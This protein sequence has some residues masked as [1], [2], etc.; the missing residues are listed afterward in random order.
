MND[1]G[2]DFARP[3]KP[4]YNEKNNSFTWRFCQERLERSLV[5]ATSMFGA[6]TITRYG[7]VP[8]RRERRR[9]I[10]PSGVPCGPSHHSLKTRNFSNRNRDGTWA[11]LTATWRRCS[12][13]RPRKRLG[14]RPSVLQSPGG[15]IPALLEPCPTT[16]WP[17]VRRGM[18]YAAAFTMSS[19]TFFASPN[20]IMVLSM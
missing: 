10:L 8:H 3:G 14:A 16:R 15:K 17:F 2:I 11:S 9:M 13:I 19:I 20:T 7:C 1:V 12:T 4:T 6:S 18:A 5:D